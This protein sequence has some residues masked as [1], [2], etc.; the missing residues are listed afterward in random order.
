VVGYPS[1]TSEKLNII[2]SKT[3]DSGTSLC[4]TLGI[5]ENISEIN[6]IG[7]NKEKNNP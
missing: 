7:L 4:N 5:P 6:F 2:S 1:I 3:P